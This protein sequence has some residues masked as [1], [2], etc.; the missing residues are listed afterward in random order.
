MYAIV[1]YV[2]KRGNEKE[3]KRI[4]FKLG[5]NRERIEKR[6]TNNKRNKRK[7]N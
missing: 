1:E 5:G 2:K 6:K 3:R 4:T 7:G